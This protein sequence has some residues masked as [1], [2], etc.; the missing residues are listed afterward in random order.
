VLARDQSFYCSAFVEV[1]FRK[2]EL[3]LLPGVG[4][5]HT[6]PDEIARSPLPHTAYVLRRHATVS[7]LTRLALRLRRRVRSRIASK[8]SEA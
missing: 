6:T 4:A 1:L 5:K 2:A 3:E 8:E 7:K